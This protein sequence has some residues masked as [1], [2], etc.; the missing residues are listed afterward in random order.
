MN[1]IS[2]GGNDAFKRRVSERLLPELCEAYGYDTAGFKPDWSRITEDDGKD[3]LW[4]MD[5]DVVVQCGRAGYRAPRSGSTEW[6]FWEGQKAI[7][8]RPLSL[9]AEPIITVAVLGRLHRDYGWPVGLLGCQ[10]SAGS[11]AA[12]HHHAFDFVAYGDEADGVGQILGEVKKTSAEVRKL[13]KS[14]IRL[15]EDFEPAASEPEKALVNA[16]RKVQRLAETRAPILWV[17]GPYPE[18]HVFAVDYAKGR[19]KLAPASHE[20]LSYIAT[21]PC[22]GPQLGDPIA[23]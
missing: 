19:P 20:A 10:P 7:V 4:A 11:V 16:Y 5:H 9:W 22:N 8:P 2:S 23:T 6:F 18:S 17:V 3:F 1:P 13:I 15:S 14:M 21:S 12:A